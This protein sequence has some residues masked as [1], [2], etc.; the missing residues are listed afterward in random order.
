MGIEQDAYM[1]IDGKG[2]EVLISF[3]YTD[4]EVLI[5][6]EVS[7][8]QLE[9]IRKQFESKTTKNVKRTKFYYGYGGNI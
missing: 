2:K 1:D 6:T 7:A 8:A 3:R 5:H 4:S 9:R